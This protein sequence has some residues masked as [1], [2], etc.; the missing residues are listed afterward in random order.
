MAIQGEQVTWNPQN[1][2]PVN[3][4]DS[5]GGMGAR[6]LTGATPTSGDI[7]RPFKAAWSG[8]KATIGGQNS[9][10]PKEPQLDQTRADADMRNGLRAR[11]NQSYLL[12]QLQNQ[13]QGQGPTVAGQQAQQGIAQALANAGTMAANARGTSRGLAQRSALYSGLQAQQQ[14]NRD[15]ALMRAQ[16][17]LS[18]QQQFGAVADAQRSGD[19]QARQLSLNAA[20]ANQDAAM[21]AM[22]YKTSISEGNATRAQKGTGAI[23]SS[24]GGMVKGL[25]SDIR[26]KDGIEASPLASPKADPS[27]AQALRDSLN[28]SPS[29]EQ[30]A[31]KNP[32]TIG[33][34]LDAGEAARE[35]AF[36]RALADSMKASSG[37]NAGIED[38]SGNG[39]SAGGLWGAVG[40]GMEAY[41]NSLLSDERSKENLAPVM[42]FR[43][44][45]KPEFAA[46]LAE[47]AAMSV[48]KWQRETVRGEVY[49]DARDPR[50]G[51]MAQDL[52]RSP[53]GRKVVQNTK[54]GKAINSSRALSF[55][56]AN[57]A[58]IDKRLRRLEEVLG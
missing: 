39:Q 29:Q 54:I 30:T 46:A 10:D 45:Y 15:A 17:Q 42:P 7:A 4:G 14:A 25:F 28:V 18:A 11:S 47:S 50:E 57:Q 20:K 41:G 58:G 24:V 40:G 56:L 27:F 43:Y 2:F 1:L 53:G 23:L 12:G 3:Q 52:E 16:E 38:T 8:L 33:D 34:G 31:A 13:I 5:W 26:A 21:Q 49:A 22:G 36:Q 48:P 19:M 51:V 6:M 55:A 32:M 44:R 9:F 35:A 37:S